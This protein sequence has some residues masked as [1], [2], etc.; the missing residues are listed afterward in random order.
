VIRLAHYEPDKIPWA[1]GEA[2][3]W[4]DH[5]GVR[6]HDSPRDKEYR[7]PVFGMQTVYSISEEK[8]QELLLS[9]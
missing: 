3:A 1:I 9:Q 7:D 8:F 2:G 4:A 6:R 5:L